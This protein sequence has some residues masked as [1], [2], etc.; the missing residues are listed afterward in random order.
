MFYIFPT[1]MVDRY[2][3]SS[4]KDNGQVFSRPFTRVEWRTG[5]CYHNL[6]SMF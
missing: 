3:L 5:L 4:E 6:I 1:I 2:E